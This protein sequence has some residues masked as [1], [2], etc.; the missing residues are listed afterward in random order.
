L[1]P[2]YFFYKRD[3]T[4]LDYESVDET[5][6]E[7]QVEEKDN[8]NSPSNLV[9]EA[10]FIN[11]NFSQQVLLRTQDPGRSMKFENES[12]FR[13]SAGETIAPVGYR[14]RKWSLPDDI[15]LV[16]RTELD[17]VLD[18]KERAHYLTI[19]ALNEYNPKS[20]VD[21]RKTLDSQRGAVLATELKN[22]SNK[23]AK[24][25]AQS[26]LAGADQLL[27]G[28]V[29]R[30]NPKD[31]FNHVILGIQLYNTKEF[32]TQINLNVRNMWGILR[33]II[34]ECMKLANGKYVLLR[35]PNKPQLQLYQLPQGSFDQSAPEDEWKQSQ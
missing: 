25:T 19:R 13:P 6:N 2:N 7:A 14:Y 8:I 29:S 27:L 4:Q 26:L 16:A 9:Q 22:N 34:D 11:H 5:S 30:T 28:Y 24:W 35:D 12:P 23:L 33:L 10:T 1:A 21:W 17:G 18:D 15:E 3:G 32:A 20:G 31:S